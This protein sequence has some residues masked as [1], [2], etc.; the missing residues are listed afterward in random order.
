[1]LG[2]VRDHPTGAAAARSTLACRPPHA[3]TPPAVNLWTRDTRFAA[4]VNLVARPRSLTPS[5]F[6]S[7]LEWPRVHAEPSQT[8]S[9]ATARLARAREA[10]RFPRRRE[11][12]RMRLTCWRGWTS[13]L[14]DSRGRA[15]VS[16]PPVTQSHETVNRPGLPGGSILER[17]AAWPDQAG[18]PQKCGTVASGW[19]WSSRTIMSH[20]RRR[21]PRSP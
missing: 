1:V 6:A 14:M 10:G 15:G 11:S 9:F 19:S 12:A 3:L 2:H 21:S 8:S 5:K 16:C 17:M 20:S 18:S 13:D 7:S 4:E